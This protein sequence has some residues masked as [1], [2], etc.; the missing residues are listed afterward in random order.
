M[1]I[2]CNVKRHCLVVEV[3]GAHSNADLQGNLWLA[4]TDEGD[5][6]GADEWDMQ[7]GNWKCLGF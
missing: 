6:K 1:G 4:E 2:E 7:Q 3:P 5:D